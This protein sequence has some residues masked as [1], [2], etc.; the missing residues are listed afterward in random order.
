M[1]PPEIMQMMQGGPFPGMPMPFPGMP[2]QGMPMQGMPMQGMLQ[3]GGPGHFGFDPWE[4]LHHNMQKVVHGAHP[5]VMA[6][7]GPPNGPGGPGMAVGPPIQ[8]QLG[9]LL[10]MFGDHHA[11]Q[12]GRAEG[13]FQVDDDHE[14]R[15]RIS[16]MLPGYK[17]DADADLNKNSPLQVKVL[18]HHSVVVSG[19]QKMGPIIKSWQRSFALPK[20][21]DAKEI[22]VTYNASDGNLTLD[23][24]RSNSTNAT[25]PDDPVDLEDDGMPP[26]L[27]AMRQAM[28]GIIKQ[29]EGPGHSVP[30]T[31]GF[32]LPPMQAGPD[33]MDILNGMGALHPRNHLPHTN[34]VPEHAVVN[35]VGCFEQSQLEK[36]ELKYYAESNAVNFAGMYW[37][38]RADHVPYFTFARHE[39]PLGHAFT[40]RNF[41]HED[42]KPKWGVYDGCGSPCEDD[43][44]R[45]CGCAHEPERGFPNW[46]CGMDADN[47][48][49]E[50]KR[51]A[52]Y[53]IGNS[54]EGDDGKAEGADANS[55]AEGDSE[56]TGEAKT[57]G[58]P[59]EGLQQ[60]PAAAA[61]RPHW[62]LK[63]GNGGSDAPH[64]EIVMPKGT[65]AEPKGREVLIF[66][67][68]DKEKPPSSE[69]AT[70]GAGTTSST[71]T[72][73]SK[74]KLPVDIVPDNCRYDGTVNE[75]GEQVLKCELAKSEVRNVRIKVIGEEL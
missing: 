44:Q 24:P 40:F 2:M 49:K 62:T 59:Q 71:A 54:L 56:G 17:L 9:N 69:S 74:V 7:G 66:N 68:K 65:V 14:T 34:P 27:R 11:G 37:H 52:V 8:M 45:W 41:T 61:G 43:M 75:N 33:I 23:V 51:Y 63:D 50:T 42:E 29:L 46:D 36:A 47:P 19:M 5:Q 64:I 39:Q 60:N 1:P 3:V 18:G 4:D 25:E 26:A 70:S 32:L 12:H 28:P 57:G 21:T 15:V 55:S 30:N 48:Q 72:P 22:S 35:L 73:V 10:D 6:I 38:A 13:S 58:A 67:E 31:G 20:G 53:K 16:A